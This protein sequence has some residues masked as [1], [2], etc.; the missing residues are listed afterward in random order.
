MK[1]VRFHDYGG[2]EALVHEETDRPVPAEGEVVVQ[3]A[4]T[5]FNFLDVAIRVGI[6]KA[7]LP[8]AL[9][10]TPGVDMSGLVTDIGAGVTGWNVGD[11]VVAFLPA[12]RPGAAAEYTAA[13]VELLASAPA[14]VPLP[15]ASALPVAGLT[16]LQSLREYADLQAGQRL[17]INGAGGGVG[18]YAIQL[19]KAI[20]AEVTATASP[21]SAD[22]VRQRGADRIVDYTVAPV[23]EAL[24]GQR[25]DAVLHLV[26]NTPEETAALVDLVADGGVLVSTTTPGPESPGRGVRVEQ[27]HVRSDS[28]QLAELIALVESGRLTIDV[29]ERRPLTEIAAVHDQAMAGRL[30]GKTVLVP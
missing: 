23:L 30:P 14:G 27:V 15:D 28:V 29:A 16:A 6:L 8:L 20:G 24:A 13:P 9:P 2:S 18:G 5:S 4:G 26:R 19:A 12:D 22:R 17:L 25:F 10:H 7:T 11:A 3:V 1:A 21:R